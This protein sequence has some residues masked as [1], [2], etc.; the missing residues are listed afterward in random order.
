MFKKN[1]GEKKEQ[2]PLKDLE[3]VNVDRYLPPKELQSLPV[4]GVLEETDVKMVITR[5][6]HTMTLKTQ[7]WTFIFSEELYPSVQ[8]FP[9]TPASLPL[10][11]AS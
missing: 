3:V 5:K 2:K 8:V 6:T 7:H 4:P 1:K 9:P 11:S 10:D